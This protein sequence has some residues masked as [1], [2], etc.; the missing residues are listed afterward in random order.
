MYAN[1]LKPIS[2]GPTQ[3]KNRIF[4]PPH[5]TTLGHN[6]VVTDELIAYHRARAEGGAGLIIMEGMTLH[7]SYG[8]E[9]AFLYAGSDRIIP[10]LNK[11]GETCRQFNTPVFGQLFHAGRAVRLSHD[12]SRPLTYSA[13]DIPD[14]RYRV[15]SVPMPNAMVWE[16]IESYITAAGNLI[17]AN[18]DGVEILASMGYLI[19]QF[20]N[21]QTNNREDEFGGDLENRSRLLREIL[22]LAFAAKL[23]QI[24][25]LGLESL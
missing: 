24:K 17:E 12:G 7:P 3:I 8:F 20:L 9:H 18:L 14:E 5:G 1:L 4:N 19:A 2:L 15:V 6:G 11:L 21:P 16:I 23:D 22:R 13:S 10:G 25:P